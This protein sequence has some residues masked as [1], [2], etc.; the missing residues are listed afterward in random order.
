MDEPIAIAMPSPIAPEDA[1]RAGLYALL[2]RLWAAPPDRPLLLA[3]AQ[4]AP[5]GMETL[6]DDPPAIRASLPVAWE[7]LRAASSV[8]DPDAA[9]QEYADLFL[10]V[11][12]SEV[13]LHGSHWLS[14]F[15]ME[16]P[17]VEVRASLATLGLGR[18][19]GV[20]MV[21]DHLSALCETMRALVAGVDA[22]PPF[23]LERQRV[24]FERHLAPWVS[25]CCAAISQSPIANY[26]RRVAELT[27]I[28]VALERDSLAMD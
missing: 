19:E 23:P 9:A 8:M 24:F 15:M 11:G 21:E 6:V 5:M 12:R 28:F 14:G 2:A 20:T 22:G 18:R 4:A 3:I 27:N 25:S 16:K 26:Y 10:G 7:G 13:N 1:A 17:L